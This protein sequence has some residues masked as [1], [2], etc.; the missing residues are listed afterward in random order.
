VWWGPEKFTVQN[1]TVKS[2]SQAVN[3][4]IG[5]GGGSFRDTRYFASV[6]SVG[7]TDILTL[8]YD[9]Y[10]P[11]AWFA[12]FNMGSRALTVTLRP[13]Y[14]DP[15]WNDPYN[16]IVLSTWGQYSGGYMQRIGFGVGASQ[17][18]VTFDQTV[19]ADKW[20]NLRIV[21]NNE[22]GSAEAFLNGGFLGTV[23]FTAGG[24]TSVE[25]IEIQASSPNSATAYVDNLSF[26]IEEAVV[27]E[28]LSMGLVFSD[29]GVDGVKGG[30]KAI[31]KVSL[32]MNARVLSTPDRLR[33]VMRQSVISA[34]ERS[35]AILFA[36]KDDC[37][38]PG[39]PNPTYRMKEDSGA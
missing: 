24:I 17:L 23:A 38:S 14:T 33:E 10:L 36:Y 13:Y 35:G 26:S 2:G 27:P 28:P 8:S 34:L 30:R 3:A 31:G 15:E 20:S 32:N 25:S 22:T 16:S 5:G 29:I 7:A 11:A 4:Q 1:A 39:R 18:A 9:Q 6:L 19:L 12:P 21:A 37:F